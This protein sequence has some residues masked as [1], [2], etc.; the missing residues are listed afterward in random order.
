MDHGRGPWW[1]VY[2]GDGK[3]EQLKVAVVFKKIHVGG[4]GYTHAPVLV[5]CVA[6]WSPHP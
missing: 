1:E 3:D 5:V 4:G 2:C 6:A